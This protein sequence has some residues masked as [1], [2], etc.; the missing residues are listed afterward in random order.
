MWMRTGAMRNGDGGHTRRDEDWTIR[1]LYLSFWG[2]NMGIRPV[3]WTEYPE[4]TLG[5][6]CWCWCWCWCSW[7]CWRCIVGWGS[8]LH[9]MVLGPGCGLHT[10][11]F[12][13]SPRRAT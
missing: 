7:C 12:A 11:P 3:W 5:L 1:F 9:F 6:A 4:V 10:P 8:C 2:S 13:S